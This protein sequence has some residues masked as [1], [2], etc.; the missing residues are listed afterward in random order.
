MKPFIWIGAGFGALVA[1]FNMGVQVERM[2]KD[3]EH[4]YAS[5]FCYTKGNIEAFVAK[6]G[7]DYVC[8]KQNI[9][10]K[11]LSKTMIVMPKWQKLYRLRQLNLC[12]RLIGLFLPKLPIIKKERKHNGS[13]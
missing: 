3:F 8:F 12:A 13:R 7:P 10:N 2:D 6:D 9:D 11:K 4:A 5:G 1:V